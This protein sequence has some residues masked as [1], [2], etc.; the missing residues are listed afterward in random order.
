MVSAASVTTALGKM[1]VVQ[2]LSMSHRRFGRWGGYQQQAEGSASSFL[3]LS[4]TS[5]A[6]P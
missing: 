3:S 1:S 6:Q 4:R 2:D 5:L